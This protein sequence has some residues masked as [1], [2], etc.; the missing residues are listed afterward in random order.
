M[1]YPITRLRRLR[2]TESLRNLVRE[3]HL[4]PGALIYPLFLCPGEG[5]RKEIAPMPGVFNLSAATSV[6]VG[7]RRT[8]FKPEQ[9][10]LGRCDGRPH[11]RTFVAKAEV[12]AMGRVAKIKSFELVTRAESHRVSSRRNGH[13]FESFIRFEASA[14]SLQYRG[15]VFLQRHGE[16]K[17]KQVIASLEAQLMVNQER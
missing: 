15:D 12:L 8:A 2:R 4:E 14:F 17:Q 13:R 3:T 11:S 1:E 10:S 16:G 7:G 6:V 5:V 9:L